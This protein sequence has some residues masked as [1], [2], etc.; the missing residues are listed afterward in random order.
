MFESSNGSGEIQ[1]P[2]ERESLTLTLDEDV[3]QPDQACTSWIVI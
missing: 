3:A 2:F 1:A